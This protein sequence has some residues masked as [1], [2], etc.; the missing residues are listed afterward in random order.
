MGFFNSIKAWFGGEKSYDNLDKSHTIEEEAPIEHENYSTGF[1]KFRVKDREN[2]NIE[3]TSEEKVELESILNG[4]ETIEDN[5]FSADLLESIDLA[6]KKYE[7][8]IDIYTKNIID[9]AEK[10]DEEEQLQEAPPEIINVFVYHYLNM[11]KNT[12]A[13][14]DFICFYRLFLDSDKSEEKI[15]NSNIVGNYIGDNSP[16]KELQGFIRWTKGIV[17]AINNNQVDIENITYNFLKEREVYCITTIDIYEGN[18]DRLLS[19]KVYDISS[20]GQSSVSFKFSVDLNT[21]IDFKFFNPKKFY[22]EDAIKVLAEESKVSYELA[23]KGV[24]F[25]I[26]LFLEMFSEKNTALSLETCGWAELVHHNK[27]TVQ[28]CHQY[29]FGMGKEYQDVQVSV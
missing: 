6:I 14:K 4:L 8:N 19:D 20:E 1:Y 17:A 21:Y 25:H 23:K 22:T 3:L 10:M 24:D 9:S 28:N 26:S 12:L 18:E 16:S 29:V 11:L 7:E 15:K 13:N 27:H 5:I 2:S